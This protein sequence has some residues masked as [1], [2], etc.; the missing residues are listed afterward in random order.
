MKGIVGTVKKVIET[1][2]GGTET[3]ESGLQEM[4]LCLIMKREGLR[5]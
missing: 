4:K 1:L 2:E 3:Y 5:R